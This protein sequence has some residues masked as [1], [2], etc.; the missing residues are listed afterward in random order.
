[1]AI[2]TQILLIIVAGATLYASFVHNRDKY[3]EV[4]GILP[5][6]KKLFRDS[7]PN[8]FKVVVSVPD[9]HAETVRRAI[10]EAGGG[11]EGHYVFQSFS[12]QGIGRYQPIEGAKPAIGEVGKLELVE[13]E[14]IE[15]T[16]SREKLEKVVSAIKHIHPY[17]ETVLDIYP[18]QAGEEKAA[19]HT[20]HTSTHH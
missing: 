17:E 13:A 7:S 10:G 12:T 11:S 1:M 4:L 3:N 16:V 6:F 18:L 15:V 9:A 2:M 14:R 20:E 8:S 19:V 5:D